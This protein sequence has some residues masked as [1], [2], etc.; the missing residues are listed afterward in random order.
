MGRTYPGHTKFVI[1]IVLLFMSVIIAS[2]TFVDRSPQEPLANNRI[3]IFTDVPLWAKGQYGPIGIMVISGE[4]KLKNG[5]SAMAGG[6][7]FTEERWLTFP[8]DLVIS[9][10]KKGASLKGRSYP[11]GAC[12]RVDENGM[13]KPVFD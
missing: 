13:L 3:E 11:E 7:L 10:G 1:E 8:I 12:L 9:V 2:S 6:R 4:Y 5:V